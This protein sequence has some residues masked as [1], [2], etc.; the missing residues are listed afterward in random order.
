MT[1]HPLIPRPPFVPRSAP[2]PRHALVAL[3]VAFG[4]ALTWPTPAHAAGGGAGATGSG[5]EIISSIL[6][7]GNG[8]P[9]GRRP[10]RNGPAPRCHWHTLT[11]EQVVFLVHVASSRPGLLDAAF[12]REIDR[13]TNLGVVAEEVPAPTTTVP[14]PVVP[15]D[16]RADGPADGPADV[17]TT[18]APARPVAS[19]TYWKLAVRICDGVAQ[20]MEVRSRTLTNEEAMVATVARGA[21]RR[22]T[23]LP[24]PVV[25]M[26]PPSRAGGVPRTLVGEP[27]FLSTTP[28]PAVSSSLPFGGRTVDVLAE[29]AGIEVFGGEPDEAGRAIDCGGFGVPYDPSREATPTRQA[30]APGACALFFDHATGS[31]R[32]DSWLGYV[33][34]NWRGSFRVDGGPPLP[35]DG[36]F[37]LTLTDIAVDEVDTAIRR[38][39]RPEPSR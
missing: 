17:P 27:V 9:A 2:R 38:A 24:P 32:R 37:S 13:Y 23:L 31:G 10:G 4:V 35:L 39:P 33:R 22:A 16:G 20:T 12:L 11:D 14:V 28:P 26:S 6:A 30:G 18:A 25:V 1:P 7:S 19:V 8:G 21:A 5:D 34:M 29:P 3:V 15:A 36:L